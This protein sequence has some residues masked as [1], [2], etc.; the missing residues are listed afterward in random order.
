MI[1]KIIT[2]IGTIP[3]FPCFIVLGVLSFIGVLHISLNKASN[4]GKEEEFILLRLVIVGIVAWFFAG[5]FDAIFKYFE[6]GTFEWKGIAFYGGLI[7]AIV[8]LPI[9][10]KGTREKQKTEFSIK[11]WFELL[12]LPLVSFHFWGRLGCF[13][14]GCCYGKITDS[15]FGIVFFGST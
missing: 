7:G 3:T 9:L 12:V 5:L 1:P 6:Y 2:P 13:F 14:A 15:I 8:S 11:E 4:R 10:L